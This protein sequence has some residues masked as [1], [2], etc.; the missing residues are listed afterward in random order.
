MRSDR[1]A[2]IFFVAKGSA[3]GSAD[4]FRRYRLRFP[5]ISSFHSH[6]ASADAGGHTLFP[7]LF[8]TRRT[9]KKPGNPAALRTRVKGPWM[10]ATLAFRRILSPHLLRT[11]ATE[12]SQAKLIDG[13]TLAAFVP[14][15]LYLAHPFDAPSSL[16]L[17]V[18]MSP[19]ESIKTDCITPLPARVGD[20]AGSASA[21]ILPLMCA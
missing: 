6:S 18:K 5:V 16:D 17:F 11:M 3:C 15:F 2:S 8:F 19:R 20:R 10:F 14:V 7:T 4:T 13:T 1:T 21:P 12:A 9:I